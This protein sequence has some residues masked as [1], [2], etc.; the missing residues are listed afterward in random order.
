MII[1]YIIF[2]IFLIFAML[3]LS[4]LIH[5]VKT[6]LKS[7]GKK[8]LTYSVL[9]LSGD[10]PERQLA[11]AAEQQLWLGKTYSDY[12]I[13]VNSGLDEENDKLC[14][15]TAEKYGATYCTA[16]ELAEKIKEIY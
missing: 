6:R 10:N 16:S 9:F 4:E 2:G 8:A 13:A 12:I 15:T 5:I 1:K 14:R 3:G 11:F 7:N